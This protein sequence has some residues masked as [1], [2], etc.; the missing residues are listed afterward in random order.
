MTQLK[1]ILITKQGF[2]KTLDIEEVTPEIKIAVATSEPDQA[3]EVHNLPLNTMGRIGTVYSW[4]KYQTFWFKT[5]VEGY[6]IYME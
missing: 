1:A 3:I 6:A 2:V 4:Y 5:K